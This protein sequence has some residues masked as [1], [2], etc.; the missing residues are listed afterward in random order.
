MKLSLN[1][2]VTLL[3]LLIAISLLGLLVIG[4]SSIETF[5]RHQL[6]ATNIRSKLQNEVS[7]LLEHMA[8]NINVAI[9]DVVN[10]PVS[11]ISDGIKIRVDSNQDGLLNVA[12][13]KEIAYR[14]NV[15]GYPFRV[16]YYSDYTDTS[17][18]FETVVAYN[19]TAFMVSPLINSNNYVEVNATACVN[20]SD[21]L[22]PC[23]SMSNPNVTMTSRIEMPSV[24]TN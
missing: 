4:I 10:Y 2:S 23:G 20:P 21:S 19:I 18:S 8:K 16:L 12:S 13:D 5:S 6:T 17:S 1:K 15:S 11:E 7:F 14:F 3:E 22:R 9:G 24:S